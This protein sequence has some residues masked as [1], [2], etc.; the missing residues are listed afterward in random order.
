MLT[1][2]DLLERL[3]DEKLARCADAIR[4]EGWGVL[5]DPDL[6]PGL[7]RE[8]SDF[9][10]EEI[11]RLK[12]IGDRLGAEGLDWSTWQRLVDERAGI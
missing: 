2:P 10:A 7:R 12:E 4:R 5:V 11:E 9:L 8:K 6:A 1:D 3:K